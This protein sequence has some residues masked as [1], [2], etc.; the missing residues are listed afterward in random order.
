MP[1]VK[2]AAVMA[3]TNHGWAAVVAATMTS[4]AVVSRQKKGMPQQCSQ[5]TRD[6]RCCRRTVSSMAAKAAG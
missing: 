1:V 5:R 3:V 4:T 2:F 6:S